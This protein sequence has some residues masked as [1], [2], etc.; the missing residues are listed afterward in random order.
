M[1]LPTLRR[2]TSYR[3]WS[4]PGAISPAAVAEVADPKVNF[5][6][7]GEPVSA[8][9]TPTQSVLNWLRTQRGLTGTKEGCAEGD[10][11]ACTVVVGEL[12]GDDVRLTTVNSCIQF[13]PM[14]EGK[15]LYTIES[16]RSTDGK[17]HPAQQAMVDCHG[18]QCG[19]CT[20]GIVM[21]L[22]ANYERHQRAGTRADDA[23][24]RS[25]LTGNLC[26]CTGYRP[27]LDAGKIMFDLPKVDFDRKALREKL[28]A[29]PANGDYCLEHDGVRFMAPSHLS[30][31][32]A[33][34]A[35]FPQ[36][37]VLA[38]CTDIG[39]WVSK[40]MRD[41]GDILYLGRVTELKAIRILPDVIEIGAGA[42]LTDAFA[43]LCV[44]YP[45]LTELRERFASLPIRNAGTLGGNVA[46]GSPIGDSMP[47]LMAL[48]GRLLLQSARGRRELLLDD[49]YRAYMKKDMA[50]DELVIAVIVPRKATDV[51]F[52]T[53]KLSKR[54]DSD[55]SAVCAAFAIEC[56]GDVVRSARVAF[57]GMAATVKR[58]K[59]TEAAL[60]GTDW[61]NE[62]VV[63]AA[64]EA[65]AVDYQPLSDMR[66]SAEYRLAAAQGLL[67]R[68]WLETRPA[69]PLPASAT[70][71]F[72]GDA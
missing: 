52:R 65:I 40:Q 31:L 6:L 13:M 18:S 48:N 8:E 63:K 36:A 2:T 54:F 67:Y 11:G 35:E 37:T 50:A 10:C 72:A 42:S 62:A 49:F 59:A 56:D 64:M 66:A 26:R 34:R 19:F 55:I 7:N 30:D 9:V 1:A 47:A 12:Q 46:N 68:F 53:Y 44:E 4:C 45:E 16:L 32:L 58:G 41:P 27:I 51:V 3:S 69:N 61:N 14:L 57:G 20:P 15:A 21:S 22:W 71:V 33:R 29:L 39:V 25:A 43:A 60:T 17:L 24:L 38:G 5:L 70:S 23:D 28:T